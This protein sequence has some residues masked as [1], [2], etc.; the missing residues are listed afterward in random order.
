MYP[1]QQLQQPLR[2]G[3]THRLGVAR[4]G[5]VGRGQLGHQPGQL[6]PGAAHS[7]A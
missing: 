1:Q 6:G 4:R 5:G 7:G 3:R 2:G